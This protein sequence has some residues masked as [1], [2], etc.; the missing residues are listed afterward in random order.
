MQRGTNKYTLP[1]S[2]PN[3]ET[4]LPWHSDQSSALEEPFDIVFHHFSTSA[5]ACVYAFCVAVSASIRA[6]LKLTRV[7]CTQRRRYMMCGH[8]TCQLCRYPHL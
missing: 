3:T 7:A 8:A 5:L 2:H 4:P 6:L 1:Y